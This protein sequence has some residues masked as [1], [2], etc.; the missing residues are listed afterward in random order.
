MFWASCE[1]HGSGFPS[2]EAHSG[3]LFISIPPGAHTCSFVILIVVY[4]VNDAMMFQ[5]N[6]IFTD[7]ADSTD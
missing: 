7:G 5:S 1:H 6:I 2:H 3:A 4:S